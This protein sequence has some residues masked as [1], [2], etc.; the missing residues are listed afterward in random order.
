MTESFIKYILLH[1]TPSPQMNIVSLYLR[2]KLVDVVR[3]WQMKPEKDTSSS[4]TS[5]FIAKLPTVR[6]VAAVC[7]LTK[8]NLDVFMWPS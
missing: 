4:E 6:F 2:N 3:N 5:K 8:R 7:S 1:P